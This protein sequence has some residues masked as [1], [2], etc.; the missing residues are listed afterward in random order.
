MSS[1]RSE[2]PTAQTWKTLRGLRECEVAMQ[3]AVR[4]NVNY[5][6]GA[7]IGS[8]VQPSS[9]P[10]VLDLT[11]SR[12]ATEFSK[13]RHSIRQFAITMI[14]LHPSTCDGIIASIPFMGKQAFNRCIHV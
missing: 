3:L 2:E 1:Q 6:Y 8:Q 11:F 14:F 7:M 13:P 4:P 9:D 10:C 12:P 5:I